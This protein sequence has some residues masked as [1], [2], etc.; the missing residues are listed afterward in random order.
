MFKVAVVNSRS[1]G[2]NAPDLLEELR[3]HAEVVFLDLDKKMRGKELAEKLKG[4]HFVIASVTPIYDSEF[5]KFNKDVLLIA[6][7]GIGVD[8]VDTQAATEEGVIVTRVPGYKERDAVAELAVSL[9]LNVIRKVCYG[10]TLVRQGKWGERAKIVGFNIK[11]KT[12][13]IIGIG[14]IG[15][16]VAEIFSRGFQARVIAYDPYVRQEDARKIGAELVDLETL[17]RESDIIMLHAPLT[18]E[19]Y[20]MIGEKEFSIMKN[21]VI[22][23]NAARGELIDTQALIKALE[24]GKVSGVGLDV[25]EGEPIDASHPILKYDN[26]VIT[27]HVGANTREGLRGMDESNVDAILK[28]IQG[29]PPVEYMVNPEVLKKGTRAR[30]HTT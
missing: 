30:L 7:H 25:I 26:V 8:N 23:V 20:H 14:N 1:F 28:V 16:R 21:G 15:G 13:G 19:N 18:K 11:G 6:R 22:L 4:Y 17:L 5:F 24:S 3:K 29:V 10:N 2:V 12:V 9:C 27:P